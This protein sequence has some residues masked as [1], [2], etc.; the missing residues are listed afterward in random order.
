MPSVLQSWVQDI[1]MMQQS[2]LL[3]AIRGPDGVEKYSPA[4]PLL[5]WLRRCILVSSFDKE[6]LTN[7]CDKRGGSFTGP[8]FEKPNTTIMQFEPELYQWEIP[9]RQ[10]LTDYMTGSD[11][12]P[13][14]FHLHFIHAA[15]VLGYMHPDLRICNYWYGVYCRLVTDFHL[16]VESKEA[17]MKRLGDKR[18]DWLAVA[19]QATV[20]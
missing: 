3:G 11:A 4:K 15:E 14:H 17:F 13:M 5:R 7:P 6:V 9:M 19:D 2:V 1:S 20:K 12:M 8:S 10:I 18:D 16:N